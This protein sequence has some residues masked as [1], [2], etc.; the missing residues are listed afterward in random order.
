MIRVGFYKNKVTEHEAEIHRIVEWYGSNK[1]L[2]DYLLNYVL[3]DKI[4]LED[5]I[6]CWEDAGFKNYTVPPKKQVAR[7]RKR[8]STYVGPRFEI[9]TFTAVGIVLFVW[10]VAIILAVMVAA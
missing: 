5:V 3:T 10:S 1:D 7:K 8:R 2:P 6:T 9:T 4:I